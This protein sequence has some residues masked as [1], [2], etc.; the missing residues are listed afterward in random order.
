MTLPPNLQSQL[1]DLELY[2]DRADRIEALIAIGEEFRNPDR[3]AFPRD[4]AC[5]VPGCESEAFVGWNPSG[6]LAIAIDNPQGISA[7]AM[8]QILLTGVQGATVEQ[9]RAIPDDIIYV[10]FGRELSMGKSMGLT[11]MVRMVKQEFA[12]TA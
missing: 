10:I 4:E 1:E 2:P 11:G 12:K 8:A 6:E 9:V 7:M 5:R 3:T